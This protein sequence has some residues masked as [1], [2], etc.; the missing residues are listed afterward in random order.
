MYQHVAKTRQA[1][2]QTDSNVRHLYGHFQ[3]FL[4]QLKKTIFDSYMNTIWFII[5]GSWPYGPLAMSNQ[6]IYEH[7]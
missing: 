6:I 3:L 4:F 1:K 5:D 7:L 2:F